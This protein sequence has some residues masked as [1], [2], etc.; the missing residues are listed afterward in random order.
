M[1]K[2]TIMTNDE[3]VSTGQRGCRILRFA[4][5]RAAGMCLLC[6][7]ADLT[8]AVPAWPMGH[9]VGVAREVNKG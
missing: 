9:V 3:F 2:S 4:N 8:Q 6:Q 7:I 1:T 5:D